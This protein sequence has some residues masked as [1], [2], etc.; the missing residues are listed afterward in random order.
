M[1]QKE[2][3]SVKEL[4]RKK[5]VRRNRGLPSRSISLSFRLSKITAASRQYCKALVIAGAA[6]T[7]TPVGGGCDADWIVE[8]TVTF[9]GG[10]PPEG[11]LQIDGLLE[12]KN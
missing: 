9:F 2:S 11:F 3:K 5:R 8:A 10:S 1:D 4:R 7:I 6:D 12:Y